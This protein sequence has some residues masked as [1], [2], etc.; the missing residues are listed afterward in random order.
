MLVPFPSTPAAAAVHLSALALPS[1][2]G[3]ALLP[4]LT[5]QYEAAAATF[6]S[7]SL[8]VLTPLLALLLGKRCVLY[9]VAVTTVWL[10]AMRS[11]GTADGIGSRLEAVT[12]DAV[13]P[14]ALPNETAAEVQEVARA[15][16]G[17][18]EASQVAALPVVLGVLLL[19]ASYAASGGAGPA[20]D[21]A[22][23][24]GEGDVTSW[25]RSAASSWQPISQACDLPAISRQLPRPPLC[26]CT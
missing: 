26:A 16:D 3:A 9:A 6:P 24:L 21:V 22:E 14:A 18:P 25:F 19:A 12:A 11:V 15:L 17:T 4:V 1:A 10:T 5:S 20:T 8:E 7:G 13:L 23:G 2:G